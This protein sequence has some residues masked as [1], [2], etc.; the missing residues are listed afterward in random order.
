MINASQSHIRYPRI[1]L[2][3]S[4]EALA[5]GQEH[6][7]EQSML[8]HIASEVRKVYE[9][10]IEVAIVLGGGNIIRGAATAETGVDRAQADYM[11]ML[12]TVINSLA[13]QDA[14][15]RDGIV[16]RLQTAIAMDK[17]AEPYIRRR[18][19]R[20]LEKGRVIILA[21]GTGDPYFTTDT[22]AALRAVELHCNIL[23]KGT[24]VDGVYD[25]DPKRYSLARRFSELSYREALQKELRVM[26]STALTLCQENHLP[27]M[28]YDLMVKG[29]VEQIVLGGIGGTLV[30]TMDG[31][32]TG[33][34]WADVH[35]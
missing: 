12:A 24:K 33:F 30:H 13:L 3:F 35:S 1:M 8:A 32:P 27:I 21:A 7:I 31:H 2:K 28:V 9:R 4:G 20:H 25:A 22:A 6:G 5:R 23:I 14:L 18:A 29:A 16:T 34:I 11:G 26:D 17:I 10:G 15:E 19:L